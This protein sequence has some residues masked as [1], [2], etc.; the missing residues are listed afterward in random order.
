MGSLYAVGVEQ[1]GANCSQE[2]TAGLRN[3]CLAPLRNRL[4]LAF[5]ET[6]QG[7]G[8]AEGVNDSGVG[9]FVVHPSMEPY[10]HP[11]KQAFLHSVVEE[12]LHEYF[13]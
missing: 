13:R 4:R 3:A 10:L 12:S 1:V 2:L 8:A 11:N 5:A 9:M 6:S 7:N